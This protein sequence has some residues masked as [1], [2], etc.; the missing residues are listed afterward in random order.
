MRRRFNEPPRRILPDCECTA[1]I[2][3]V[4]A[5]IIF[6]EMQAAWDELYLFADKKTAVE[7][8][9]PGSGAKMLARW[10]DKQDLPRLL[11]A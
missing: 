6:R 5:Y 9:G 4:E 7:K 8:L 10:V 1:G 2:G 11:T 3:Q